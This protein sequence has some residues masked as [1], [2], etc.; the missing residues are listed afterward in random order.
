[1]SLHAYGPYSVAMAFPLIVAIEDQEGSG[2]GAIRPWPPS[3]L[4]MGLASPS[5]QSPGSKKEPNLLLPGMHVFRNQ[6]VGGKALP[7]PCWGSLKSSPDPLA[8]LRG[9]GRSGIQEG[10]ERKE[11]GERRNMRGEKWQGERRVEWGKEGTEKGGEVREKERTRKGG[12]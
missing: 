4:S 3:G 7:G 8:G 1:M 11:R 2:G 6:N 12:S 9:R 10:R 5:W